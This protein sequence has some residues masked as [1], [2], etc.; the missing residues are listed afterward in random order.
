MKSINDIVAFSN[1]T[2]GGTAPSIPLATYAT[3]GVVKVDPST[4]T[5]DA[6]GMIAVKGDLFNLS[7]YYD[8]AASDGRFSAIGHRHL[9]SELDGKPTTLGGYGITDAM[10]ASQINTAIAQAKADIVNS[11]PAALDTLN[12]LATALGNDPNFATTTATALGNRL[13]V[14]ISTQ[15]LT[16]VQRAN[17]RANLGLGNLSAGDASVLR[18]T[19]LFGSCDIGS[20]NDEWF[21]FQTDRSKFYM[22]KSLAVNG[23]VRVYGTNSYINYNE[24]AIAGNTIYHQGNINRNDIDFVAKNITAAGNVV[25]RSYSPNVC[26]EKFSNTPLGYIIKTPIVSTPTIQGGGMHVVKINGYAYGHGLPIS[27]DVVFY[28]YNGFVSYRVISGGGWCPKLT[29][30][31]RNGLVEINIKNG[32]YCTQMYVSYFQGQSETGNYYSNWSIISVNAESEYST[33][34]EVV[35]DYLNDYP[36]VTS[37][38]TQFRGPDGNVKWTAQVS[39]AGDYLE[40][41]NASDV[42]EMRLSQAG[43]IQVRDDIEAFSSFS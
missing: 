36:V 39:A 37:K 28:Q 15:G 7:N 11:S 25:S 30:S 27:L 9:F 31:R 32:S 1:G 33:D 18:I 5:V 43:K 4:M 34:G 14:D 21:H 16:D 29:I 17:G 20:M 26:Q 24:G 40:F 2:G 6:A 13:R 8:K 23:E 42:L 12:E 38:S 41:Y 3:V 35:V 22:N 19:T 10:T